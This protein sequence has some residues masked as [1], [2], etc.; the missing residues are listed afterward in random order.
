MQDM[1]CPDVIIHAR[2]LTEGGGG[3]LL[4]EFLGYLSKGEQKI[5]F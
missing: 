3:W 5:S 2:R 1:I 4:R